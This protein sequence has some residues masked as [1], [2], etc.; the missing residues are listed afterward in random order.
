MSRA[1]NRN[2]GSW[3]GGPG[4]GLNERA[5]QMGDQEKWLEEKKREAEAKLAAREEEKA[6]EKRAA[7]AGQSGGQGGK[8]TALG[9]FSAARFGLK[10][11]HGGGDLVATCAEKKDVVDPKFAIKNEPKLLDGLFIND[12]N[13]MAKFY[14]MQ[15][16]EPP[17]TTSVKQEIKV[18]EEPAPVASPVA[19]PVAKATI[20][21]LETGKP[22]SKTPELWEEKNVK[23]KKKPCI[24]LVP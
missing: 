4:R 17:P 24:H 19:S 16:K 7:L 5:K 21:D 23:V 6:A 15:G 9:K 18:K 1:P 20:I 2:R 10:G 14:Q 11:K 3:G 13:F 12:G 22:K 8:K